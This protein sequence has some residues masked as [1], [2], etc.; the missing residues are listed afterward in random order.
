MTSF[1]RNDLQTE[2]AAAAA[3]L[4]AEDG[5]DYA[6]AKRKAA[7]EVMGDTGRRRVLP[8]NAAVEHEL[9]RYLATF[10]PDEHRQRLV[11]MRALALE[12]ME[13][14]ADFNPHLVGAVLNGTATVHSDLHLHL[15]TDDPK[16]VLR[17][18]LNAGFDVESVEPAQ[19]RGDAGAPG[20]ELHFLLPARDPALPRRVGVVLSVHD[21]DAIRVAARQRSADPALHA[22]EAAGRANATALRTLLQS[23]QAGR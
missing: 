12:L 2:I 7:D 18:L 11:A 3:R 1:P 15:F 21:R 10:E 23:A 17:F 6:T 9:R 5:L 20:E 4:I 22:I 14:L 13:R 19:R 8:D 16:E